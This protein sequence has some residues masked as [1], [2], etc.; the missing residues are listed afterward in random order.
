MK[1]LSH[2]LKTGR[3]LLA[4][5]LV[6]LST[7]GAIAA[8]PAS[9]AVGVVVRVAPPAPRFEPVPRYPRAYRPGVVVWQPG[10]WRWNS[11]AYVWVPGRYE[12][13]PRYRH[14]WV[15]GHWAARGPGWVW[16]GGHWR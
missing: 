3:S 16:I 5:A 1:K 9:A 13:V 6:G 8:A 7:L 10:Y 15:E 2:L 12:R 4:A 14:H 11:G